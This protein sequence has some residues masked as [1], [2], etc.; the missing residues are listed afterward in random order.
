MIR[1]AKCYIKNYPRPQFVREEWE[2]LNGEWFVVKNDRRTYGY[3]YVR[4]GDLW[5][6]IELWS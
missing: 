2:D 4:I 3:I 1:H 5:S 6:A